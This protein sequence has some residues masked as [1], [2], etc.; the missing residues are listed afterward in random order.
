MANILVFDSGVGGLSIASTIYEN[1]PE[2]RIIFAS[3]NAAY[4]YGEKN[5]EELVPRVIEVIEKLIC[6]MSIDIIVVACNTA[7]TVALPELRKRLSIEVVGVVPAIKPAAKLTKTQYIGML[8]TSATVKRDYTHDLVDSFANGCEV[9]ML[10]SAE[11]VDL[12]EQKLHQGEVSLSPIKEIIKPWLSKDCKIDTVV[13]ACTHFPLLKPELD[14]IFTKE[15]KDIQWVDSSEGIAKRVR[16]LLDNSTQDA[17]VAGNSIESNCAIFTKE[18]KA[19]TAFQQ[20][21]RQLDIVHIMHLK[22]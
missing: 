11:L 10:G 7:S 3:D 21:L 20:H 13:L 15:R 5:A 9:D 4:P 19:S 22:V 17:Y 16:Y 6:A 14:N 12:A 2:N 8:A 1:L 18:V